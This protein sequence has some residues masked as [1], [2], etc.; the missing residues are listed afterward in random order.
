MIEIFSNDIPITEVRDKVSKAVKDA[1]GNRLGD[2]E[3]E[4]HSSSWI[5]TITGPD[6]FEWEHEFFGPD[7]HDPDFIKQTIDSA[8]PH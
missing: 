2:W 4:I 3:A 7:E 8:L 6:G 1:I 5:I